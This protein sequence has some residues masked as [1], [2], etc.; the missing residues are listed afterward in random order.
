MNCRFRVV[1]RLDAASRRQEG[2]VTISRTALT[3]SV[4][5]LR[6]RRTYVLPLSTVAEIVCQRQLRAELAER[7]AEKRK[8]RKG[9]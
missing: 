3:F 6:R 4:R 2:T 5:P 8:N 7:R 1:G 9:R